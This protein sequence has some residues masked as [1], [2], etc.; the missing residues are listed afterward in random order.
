[1]KFV[2]AYTVSYKGVFYD[3][4]ETIDIDAKDK[5]EM[6]RHGKIEAEAPLPEPAKP[7]ESTKSEPKKTAK[8]KKVD[9]K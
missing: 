6:S 2:P 5:E 3:A 4:G 7:T 8:R 1:M 9:K